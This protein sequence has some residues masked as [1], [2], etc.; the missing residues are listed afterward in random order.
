VKDT[1]YRAN[2]V[3]TSPQGW[4]KDDCLAAVMTSFEGGALSG[5]AFRVTPTQTSVLVTFTATSDH[6][7]R[8]AARQAM[9]AIGTAADVRLSV[10][11]GR[12]YVQID[13]EETK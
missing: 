13:T 11:K 8:K 1:I 3:A 5:S 2:V 7:A 9:R 12:T 6:D 4:T 10:K